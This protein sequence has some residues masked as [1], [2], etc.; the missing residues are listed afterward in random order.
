MMCG[1]ADSSNSRRLCESRLSLSRIFLTW[2]ILLP[3]CEVTLSAQ[4]TP[5]DVPE[6][7][8]A[9]LAA[10]AQQIRVM[11]RAATA[12]VAVFGPRGAG[13]GSGVI[14][15]PD[16]YALTNFHVAD[17]CGNYMR[18]GLSDGRL[19]DAVIVGLDP[20][21]DVALIKLV[22]RDDFPTAPLGNSDTLNVGQ[23]C[24]AVGNP[25]LLATDFQPTVTAG[26]ISGVQRYQ[27]PAKTL[28]EYSDCLQTDAAIN[29]GNSG[30]PLF[31]EHG[32]VIGINGRISIEKRGR[33]NV[34][35]GYAISINQI[36]KFMGYLRSG[37][38][39][40]HAT[41][42]FTVSDDESGRVVVTN[43]LESSDAYRRGIRF[44]DE[45]ISLAG[46]P[47]HSA[48]GLKNVIGTFPRGWRIP[49]V[50][51]REGAQ[52]E[53]LVRLAGLHS[54]EALI[55]MLEGSPAESQRRP[56]PKKRPDRKRERPKDDE[57][58]EP[59][60]TPHKGVKI[61][62]KTQMPAEIK[63][64]F[65]ARRGFA[66][67]YFNRTHVQRIC[68]GLESQFA[69]LTAAS[70]HADWHIFG[71][72]K[73]GGTFEIA[74]KTNS[75]SADLPSGLWEMD[76]SEDLDTQLGPNGSGGML[77]A[78]HLL[79]DLMLT[80]PGQFGDV[81][82]L[83]TAPLPDHERVDVLVAIRQAVEMRVYTD[84]ENG[85]LLALELFTD[86]RTDPCEIHFDI[87]EPIER[88]KQSKEDASGAV[89]EH[90][91]ATDR[92]PMRPTPIHDMTVRHGDDVYGVFYIERMV[93]DVAPNQLN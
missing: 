34:G 33:V 48:N 37:R 2:L 82:Y 49:V 1:P 85:R 84:V 18:C 76:A 81:T 71:S 46:R 3:V 25:F 53:V 74:L 60:R 51:Q 28:L 57:L 29:P 15:S 41:L 92:Q 47:V 23:A 9:L 27:Y 80:G 16:G 66:N 24:F 14:I 35:V 59:E 91:E 78:L 54:S 50:Y 52:F 19:Y 5:A 56:H 86:S 21:G 10:E 13:G 93:S 62:T 63:E 17:P 44:D 67:Y 38:I 31:D 73:T 30:G 83:G 4:P 77:L 68:A 75:A 36:K 43:M 70:S 90:E 20:T 61:A 6:P 65:E 55:A 32:N 42:G 7:D 79:R 58:E 87:A 88:S 8:A 89:E 40:D 39:V 11:A 45:I 22:G 12:T 69:A 64:L 72:L 26:I